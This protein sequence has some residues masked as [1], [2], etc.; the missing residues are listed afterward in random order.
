MQAKIFFFS[1]LATLLAAGVVA[2]PT[3]IKARDIKPS[4][5]RSGPV[6]PFDEVAIEVG[7]KKPR[8]N[9]AT[10]APKDSDVPVLSTSVKAR[11][12]VSSKLSSVNWPWWTVTNFHNR[13]FLQRETLGVL[14]YIRT[15]K[16]CLARY[17]LSPLK[18]NGATPETSVAILHTFAPLP[19]AVATN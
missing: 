9:G 5:G 15:R 7:I 10:I 12:L 3:R 11:D 19:T 13:R 1:L 6:T 14:L 17:S 4:H 2:T 8:P 16:Q 18:A